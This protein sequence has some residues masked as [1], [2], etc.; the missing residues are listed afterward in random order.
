MLLNATC[1]SALSTALFDPSFTEALNIITWSHA[2]SILPYPTF[3]LKRSFFLESAAAGPSERLARILKARKHILDL[4]TEPLNIR[5]AQNR[6]HSDLTTALP[7]LVDYGHRRIGDKHTW[8]IALN[9][10]GIRQPAKPAITTTHASFRVQI[11]FCPPPTEDHH[12]RLC[13][14][15]SHYKLFTFLVAAPCLKYEYLIDPTDGANG[16]H[17]IVPLRYEDISLAQIEALEDDEKPP[18]WGIGD[19]NTL[20][21]GWDEFGCA[22]PVVGS[23]MMKKLKGY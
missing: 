3:I 4:P 17:I 21:H 19:L 10:D 13:F 14:T 16:A 6:A 5:D 23:G 12:G 11:V 7:S 22:V 2:Y 9:T 20:G 8:T 15:P 18:G 1:E